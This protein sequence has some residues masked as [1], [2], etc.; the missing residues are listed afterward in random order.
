[1]RV[2]CICISAC[3]DKAQRTRRGTVPID[4]PPSVCGI[5][6]FILCQLEADDV[7]FGIAASGSGAAVRQQAVLAKAVEATFRS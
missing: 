1:M 5:I 7:V 2:R 4:G 3:L 6:W